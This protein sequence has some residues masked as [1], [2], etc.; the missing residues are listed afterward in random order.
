MSTPSFA[1][2]QRDFFADLRGEAVTSPAMA[3]HRNTGARAAI[4]ALAANY[5]VV[6]AV[7]G[8]E[9]FAAVAGAF[10]RAN[11][12]ADPRLS[13]YGAG[14]AGFLQGYTP[15]ADLPWLPDVAALE[16]M[17]L[18]A[19]F[20]ADAVPLDGAAITGLGV[21]GALVLALH[22]AA[23]FASFASPAVSIWQAHDADNLDALNTIAWN[24]ECALVT[25]PASK[26]EILPIGLADYSFLVEI[27][28][29][30]PVLTAIQAAIAVAPD[31]DVAA[32]FAR[33][34][35]AGAFVLPSHR[36]VS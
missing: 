16:R 25:R 26:V 21:D 31:T 36:S 2:F 7:F 10:V 28:V 34:I 9:P 1:R 3:V 29:G 8:E 17:W 22:P 32:L 5:P 13:H 23:R 6:R 27:A 4:E 18:E 19:L 30:Q 11:P 33:L 15:V 12:P 20:A 24:A 14:F 35:S